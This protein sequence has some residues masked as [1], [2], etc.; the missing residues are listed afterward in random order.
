MTYSGSKPFFRLLSRRRSHAHPE[1]RSPGAAIQK[2]ASPG[3]K[4]DGVFAGI[5]STFGG[6][7][8]TYG[9]VMEQGAFDES[10]ARFRQSGR[11]PPML[12]NHEAAEPSSQWLQLRATNDGLAASGR[13][14]LKIERARDAH[15]LLKSGSPL[16]APPI[17]CA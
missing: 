16:N 11:L 6:D 17:A 12:W 4:S 5:A 14:E 2:F 9:F 7:P 10:L 3:D 15:A 8:G 13:L 1:S